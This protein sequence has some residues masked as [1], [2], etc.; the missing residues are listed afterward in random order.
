MSADGTDGRRAGVRRKEKMSRVT[1]I[2]G[3][4][5]G[6]M[7]ALAAAEAGAETL[8]LEKNEKTGKKLYIT[9]KGRCNVTNNCPDTETFLKEVMRN[10]RF[11]YSA[12][13]AFTPQDMMDTLERLGCPVKTERGRRV[14]P[15][16]DKASDVTRA[17]EAG[18]KRA[19]GRIC[20]NT[21]VRHVL[22]EDGQVKGVELA[23]G[24]TLFSDKVIVCTGGLSYPSTGSTGDGYLFAGEC[25]LAV[26]E[27]FPSLT[28]IETREKWPSRLSGLSLKNV[29]LSAFRGKKK[30][31]VQQ[32]EMLFTHFGISGPLVLDL[33]ATLAGS[34]LEDVRLEID[35]KPAL[36]AE[37]LLS[38]LNRDLLENSAGS[39]KRV[40]KGLLPGQMADLYAGIS[41]VDTALRCAQTG[42][43]VRERIA[44]HLKGI[45]LTPLSL[46]SFGEAIV[47][48]GG[49]D[50]RGITPSTM[51][52]KTVKGL[53]FA[54][55]VLDIDARTG[56]Y[57]LQIAF[58]T[59]RA[60]GI[61]A[62]GADQY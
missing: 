42:T 17:L 7:A 36:S 45:P 50:L 40:L 15:V 27:R 5:A 26:T 58:S 9:G 48:R 11:L 4:A 18:V 39:L 61:S 35:M 28:G 34:D 51:E 10:P 23:D 3:G 32:G 24:R 62:A 6:L 29:A 54:G 56:G 44:G 53:Y 30:L 12:L 33:S 13:T 19:G 41:G 47:T 43:G 22:A 8:L 55:E 20:L 38:R 1:V 16:S 46:R 14:F 60:A 2:G 31:F 59:G 25:G 57:N 49:V 37:Q 52:C 21:A